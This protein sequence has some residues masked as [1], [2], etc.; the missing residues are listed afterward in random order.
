[1]SIIN[2]DERYKDWY[3]IGLYGIPEE[4]DPKKPLKINTLSPEEQKAYFQDEE[5]TERRCN[6]ET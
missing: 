6:Y 2:Y 1:M 3:I 5:I 4:R